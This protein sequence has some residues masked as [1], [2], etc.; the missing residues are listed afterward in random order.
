MWVV[1]TVNRCQTLAKALFDVL[2]A[3]V[4]NYH[5]RYKL[6]DRQDKHKLTIDAF[7]QI[8]RHA[9]AVTTQVCEMSLDLDADV[10]ISEVAPVSSL[11][12]R[13]GRANRHR[14]RGDDFRAQLFT[15]QTESPL[16]Y[17]KEELLAAN[18]LLSDIGTAE[19]SQQRLAELLEVHSPDEPRTDGSSR[20]LDSGYF[21]T[22][23]ALRDADEY[24]RPCVLDGEDLENGKDLEKVRRLIEQRKPYD[25]FIVN[26]PENFLKKVIDINQ[27]RPSWLPKYLN[28]APAAFYTKEYG[29]KVKE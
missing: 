13:F 27:A 23:G 10:L 3:E 5:S 26:V 17:T 11:I 20:F 25:S 6:S 24:T 16:P 4:I 28:I 18:N 1:N 14:A 21:A 15:Y 22:P 7:Q 8:T 19:V 9:I 12:Q 2:G 29:Y